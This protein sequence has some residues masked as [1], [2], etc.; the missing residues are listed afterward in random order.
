MITKKKCRK[1]KIPKSL[2]EFHKAK[3]NKD[4]YSTV[5]K[6]CR[7][8]EHREYYQRP[9]VKAKLK[10]TRQR[11]QKQHH[12]EISE[13]RK[14]YRQKHHA[15]IIKKSRCYFKE[16]KRELA[17]KQKKQ[18]RNNPIPNLLSRARNRAKKK[19]VLF[20]LTNADIT[21]PAKC[22]VLGIEIKI[23]NGHAC[24]NSPSLDEIV[25]GGG[26]IKSNVIIVSHK[27]NTIK[28]NATIEELS[29]V[30]KFYKNLITK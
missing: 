11:Y 17:E 27:A 2:S 8:K 29:K 18:R 16:H 14:K 24:D 30:V 3:T 9:E 5:C 20:N 23:G 4:N 25:K 28:S 1:C 22:P 15:E 6:I 26:Y 12:K 21:M 10:I 13:Q 19:G 7:Q